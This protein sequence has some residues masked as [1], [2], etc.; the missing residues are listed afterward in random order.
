MK[1]IYFIRHGQTEWNKEGRLQGWLN[2][3]LTELGRQ[4]ARQLI[5]E[6][7]VQKVYCSDLGRAIETA[8]IIFPQQEIIQLE[9]LREIQL[10]DWQGCTYSQLEGDVRFQTY[11]N[12][13]S[14]FIAN[15]EE[16]FDC[17][18][19]RMLQVFSEIV[20]GDATDIAVI[21]HGVSLLCLLLALRGETLLKF[22]HHNMLPSCGVETIYF[23]EKQTFIS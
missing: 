13:P 22:Q 16:S 12:T 18:Q 15:K 3:N 17:V 1:T 7:P 11:L 14:S 6:I 4:Q 9:Q 23:F 5:G 2:S 10:G 19:K 20:N 8:R 21:G